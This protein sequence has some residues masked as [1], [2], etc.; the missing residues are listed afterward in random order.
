MGASGECFIAMF[1]A[2]H[3]SLRL[4]LYIVRGA[5]HAPRITSNNARDE[6]ISTCTVQ[7]TAV[8]L[9]GTDVHV[10][11]VRLPRH[12]LGLAIG[13]QD[14]IVNRMSLS[15]EDYL[16]GGFFTC[17][18]RYGDISPDCRYCRDTPQALL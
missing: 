18:M 5:R 8:Q 17:H 10:P 6:T 11:Y 14:V 4:T 7:A 16:Y 12:H 15:R 2:Q 1:I 13:P 3:Y 9:Y